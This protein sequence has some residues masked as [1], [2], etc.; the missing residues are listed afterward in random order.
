MLADPPPSGEGER[1]NHHRRIRQ[2]I[3]AAAVFRK[4]PRQ[5][6]RD[7]LDPLDGAACKISRS[8]IALHLGADFFPARGADLGVDAA[9][10]DDLDIAVGQQQVDQH[11]V[12]V[13]GV[14]DAQLRENIQRAFPRGL[15]AEQRRAVQCAFH[16]KTDL[17]GMRG[18]AR[19]DRL[20]DRTQH[21]RRKNPPHPPAVLKKMPADAP[22]IHAY[23]LPDAPPPPKLPPPPLNPPLSPELLLEPSPPE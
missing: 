4:M 6:A 20:L 5:L 2:F 14:P 23:Q 7:R 1:L 10:G 19:P 18:L 3:V 21:L 15:I 11:A 13:S 16:D 17:A 22:D 8:E 12:V 9:I